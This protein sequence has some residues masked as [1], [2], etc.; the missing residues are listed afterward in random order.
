MGACSPPTDLKGRGEGLEA[1]S[2]T[3]GQ[4]FNQSCLCNEVSIKNQKDRVQR[5]SGSVHRERWELACLE[6]T[7]LVVSHF[8]HQPVTELYSFIVNR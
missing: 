7:Y 6:R 4:G 5:A 8:F 2:V 1:E 3:N